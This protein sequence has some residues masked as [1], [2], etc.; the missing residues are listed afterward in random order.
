MRITVSAIKADTGSP[1]G[2]TKP[3]EG[4]IAIAQEAVRTEIARGFLL[5]GRVTY[6]G[7]DLCLTMVHT[8]D[9]GADRVHQFAW[10]TFLD[11][12]EVARKEGLYA[13]GQDLLVDAPSGNIRGA[14][15]GVAEIAFDLLPGH[16]PAETFMVWTGDKCAPGM[17][18]LPLF[19]LFAD[20]MHNSGLLL[21]P[22]LYKGFTV[23]V[24]DMNNVAA[25]RVTQIRLPEEHLLLAAALRNPDRFAVEAVHSRAYPDEQIVSVAATRL[26]NIKGVYTGKDDP[27]AIIRTQR[28]FPAPEEVLEPWLTVDQIVTGDCRGSH[29]MPIMPSPINMGVTGP[30][31]FPII[32]AVG[33]SLNADGHLS[34]AID[35]FDNPIWDGVRMRVQAKGADLRRQ[36]FFGVALASQEEQA[37]TGL[38]ERDR[39]LDGRFALRTPEPILHGRG[40]GSAVTVG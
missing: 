8:H 17:F 10:R 2:H 9:A 16:R 22:D 24:I 13:A 36:G 19:L 29:N 7:D 31:C 1:A 40:N 5:D 37:Y 25:D 20:P 14:G 34:E 12:T 33:Y 21:S 6:T 11:T 27:C 39:E 23:T 38:Q 32:S 26:H 15:P 30:Y 4:M 18:N 28:I 35:F 3:S